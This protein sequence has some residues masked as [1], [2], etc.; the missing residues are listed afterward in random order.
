VV[1]DLWMM[2]EANIAS[3]SDHGRFLR[4]RHSRYTIEASLLALFRGK[5]VTH[6]ACNNSRKDVRGLETYVNIEPWG[7]LFGCLLQR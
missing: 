4:I 2:D 5:H 6:S 7:L 1:T 3:C